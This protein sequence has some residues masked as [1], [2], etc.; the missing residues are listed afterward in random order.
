M[1]YQWTEELSIRTNGVNR[2]AFLTNGDF[3][4][5]VLLV[6][7]S[8]RLVSVCVYWTCVAN[9]DVEFLSS[10][11]RLS[12]NATYEPGLMESGS[13]VMLGYLLF[14]LL[15]QVSSL[16]ISMLFAS[17][18]KLDQSCI[19]FSTSQ[20]FFSVSLFL[21]QWSRRLLKLNTRLC[22]RGVWR[23]VVKSHRSYKI[24]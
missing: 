4:P 21:S 7:V 17:I 14:K 23:T 11:I 9:S 1:V 15:C 10:W 12:R 24:V 22:I 16:S 19:F 13:R 6:R 18:S 2:K 8:W 3:L 20:V 5:M